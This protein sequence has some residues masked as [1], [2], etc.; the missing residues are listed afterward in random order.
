MEDQVVSQTGT[1]EKKRVKN[2]IA[3][4]IFLAG[5]FL[6]SVFVDMVQLIQG[7]GFS[8]RRLKE[9]GVVE[10]AGKTWVAYQE[11]LVTVRAITDD[12]CDR[13]KPDE[14]LVWLRRVVPTVEPIKVD[15]N[16]KEGQKLVKDFHVT[17]LPAA[18][19]SSAIEKTD[20][21][22]KAEQLFTKIGKDYILNT[23]ELGVPVGRYLELPTVSDAD[24]VT[25]N[26]EAKVRIIEFTDFQCPYCK[27]LHT[28]IRELMDQMGDK[29]YLVFKNF[30]LSFH[31]Q[32]ENAALAGAC[33]NAQG[34][35]LPFADKLFNSQEDWGQT[36]GTQKFKLY[37][38]QLGL[39]VNAF[40]KCLDEKQ[41]A[42]K[43]SQDKAEGA[44]FN[45]SGT[46]SLFINGQFTGGA[47][48]FDD[49][50]KMVDEEL[51]K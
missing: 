12:T 28:S 29:V 16:S 10:T 34:K 26:P 25:G 39:D 21:F 18:V 40:N 14:V 22:S 41:F 13:C 20:F 9:V 47:L 51:A 6:G 24:A 33:A 2:L 42:E 3:L 4:S 23:T 8:S 48:S 15:V 44:K 50:K 45:I 38:R 27:V 36:S 37:A 43:I 7:E 31:G 30:P 32:A 17:S 46:P 1:G 35:F 19:F 11:P 49:L 5:L